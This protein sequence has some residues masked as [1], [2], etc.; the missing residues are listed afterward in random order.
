MNFSQSA[1]DCFQSH[2][3]TSAGMGMPRE[4]ALLAL[5]E[6]PKK[7]MNLTHSL[8]WPSKLCYCCTFDLQSRGRTHDTG[9]VR[10][11]W[12]L[13]L[14]QKNWALMRLAWFE[15]ARLGP[16][17]PHMPPVSFLSRR[18]TK[19]PGTAH[20]PKSLSEFYFWKLVSD[21]STAKLML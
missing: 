5:R 11:W 12:D 15:T 13:S 3:T 6:H 1:R 21:Y 19:T 9:A 14:K 10:R 8:H 20:S 4:A 16:D 2:C 18:D 7:V 17:R